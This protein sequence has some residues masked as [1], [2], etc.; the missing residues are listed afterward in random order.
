MVVAELANV[1]FAYPGQTSLFTALNLNLQSG[2]VCGLLGRNGAGKTTLLKL[3][4][5]LVRPRGGE[6]RLFGWP[7]WQRRCVA[8]AQVHLV[9]ERFS[10]PRL[11]VDEY[12]H[13]HS[14]YYPHFSKTR[15]RECLDR[16]ELRDHGSLAALSFGQQKA[17]ALSF[18]FSTGAP[19]LV[20]D[21]PTNGLDIP[22]KR[23][24]RQIIMETAGVDRA[25]LIST[26][27][28]RDLEE[29]ISRVLILDAGQVIHDA[30]NTGNLEQLFVAA[31]NRGVQ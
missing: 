31:V 6:A 17:I 2:Q 9:G 11:S 13:L 24:L 10:L 27:Q 20:L 25:I 21:E 30:A 3:T 1:G 18:A 19:L 29:V 5:G 4:L 28:V 16:F 26:H 23:V 15:F 7:A 22:A 12:A 8:L 14:R